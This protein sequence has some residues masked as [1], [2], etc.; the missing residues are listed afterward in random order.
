MT[1]Y[2]TSP[3]ETLRLDDIVV[4]RGVS[5]KVMNC[6]PG[7]YQIIALDAQP[8]VD[9]ICICCASLEHIT[10]LVRKEFAKLAPKESPKD[11]V[12][13]VLSKDEAEFLRHLIGQFVCGNGPAKKCA[14]SVHNI[15]Q[16]AGVTRFEEGEYPL[17]FDA[18][19]G[20]IRCDE[21]K[22]PLFHTNEVWRTEKKYL[23]RVCMV[24][25]DGAAF[26]RTIHN[27]KD[28][29]IIY[30]Y[31]GTREVSADGVIVAS[32]DKLVE[33]ISD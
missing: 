1:T 21:V 2:T 20:G 5:H 15:L 22:E 6:C 17:S 14:D 11:D 19:W 31:E 13:I 12:T 32:G 25:P 29:A 10:E 27:T 16:K 24:R 3:T 18:K 23:V 33:K 30:G 9:T 4:L 8:Q 28:A 26:V 7:N